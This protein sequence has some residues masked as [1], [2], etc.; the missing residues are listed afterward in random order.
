MANDQPL[1]STALLTR[2]GELSDELQNIVEGAG[3]IYRCQK[4]WY[5]ASSHPRSS[6][7]H[8]RRK[9][10]PDAEFIESLIVQRDNLDKLKNTLGQFDRLVEESRAVGYKT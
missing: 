2:I 10:M 5:Y 1:T 3:A 9:P 4:C 6:I 7:K 8:C